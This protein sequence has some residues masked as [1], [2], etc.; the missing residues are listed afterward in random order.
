MIDSGAAGDF[1]DL[2]LAKK[3]GIPTQILS[4]PQAVTALDGRPLEPGRVTEA[5]QSLRL[6]ILQ[7][8]QEEIFYLIDS[9]EFPVILGHPWLH[10][11]NPRIDCI[12]ADDSLEKNHNQQTDSHNE[13][14]ES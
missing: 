11:H 9:P 3:L 12:H 10:R 6:T 13:K 14:Q 4:Y 5:T 8:Q 1:L 7:H 2:S